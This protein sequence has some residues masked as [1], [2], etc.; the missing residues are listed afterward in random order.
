MV[1]FLISVASIFIILLFLRYPEERVEIDSCNFLGAIPLALSLSSFV[2]VLNSKLPTS[3]PLTLATVCLLFFVY[4]ER[5]AKNSLI[6]W[7]IFERQSVPSVMII[8]FF[9]AIFDM[10]VSELLF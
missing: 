3:W 6:P 1:E 5:R 2:L 10:S 4:S 9:T 8:A 7:E